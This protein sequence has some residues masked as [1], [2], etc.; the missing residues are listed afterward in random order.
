MTE[1]IVI[2]VLIVLIALAGALADSPWDHHDGE[3]DRIGDEERYRKY[4][5]P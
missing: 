4:T 2:L 1:V 3:Y 5:N